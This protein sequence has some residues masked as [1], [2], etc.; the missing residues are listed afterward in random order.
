[1]QIKKKKSS[2]RG[3]EVYSGS[4]LKRKP[5]YTG[6]DLESKPVYSGGMSSSKVAGYSGGLSENELISSKL[7]SAKKKKNPPGEMEASE[8]EANAFDP[9]VGYFDV[10]KDE[11]GVF[12]GTGEDYKKKILERMKNRKK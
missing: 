9:E 11:K 10:P 8:K 5:V 4:K 3:A 6:S 1:M 7:A 12:K 2:L